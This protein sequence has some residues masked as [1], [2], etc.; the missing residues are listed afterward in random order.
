[1]LKN[2]FEIY[3]GEPVAI[4]IKGGPGRPPRWP[5][6]ELEIWQHFFVPNKDKDDF[7]SVRSSVAYWHRKFAGEG[8]RFTVNKTPV[9][10]KVQR[11]A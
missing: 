7:S 6:A 10:L 4:I 2:G 3:D 5:I 8:R 11:V 1:M 9:G